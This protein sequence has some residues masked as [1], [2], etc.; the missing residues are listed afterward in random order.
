[1]AWLFT[2]LALGSL[3]GLTPRFRARI[4]PENPNTLAC[5][6]APVLFSLLA[7]ACFAGLALPALG[8]VAVAGLV[9]IAISRT[10][11][12]FE[13]FIKKFK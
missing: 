8:F 11:Q 3:L 13:Y 6:A 9:L 2:A 5:A 1:M 7:V 12:K 10:R 4:Y